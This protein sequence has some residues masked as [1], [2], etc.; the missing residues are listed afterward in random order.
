MHITWS[1]DK[2]GGLEELDTP[3]IF[4]REG[5]ETNVISISIAIIIY[6]P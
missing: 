1:S 6:A 5:L 4:S 2:E 3:A